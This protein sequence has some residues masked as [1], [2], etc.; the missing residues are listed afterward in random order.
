DREDA[1]VAADLVLEH[2]RLRLVGLHHHL[3]WSAYG[4]PYSP[5]LDL[6]RHER[7]VEQVVEFAGLLASTRGVVVSVINLGGGFRIG[8]PWKFG[9]PGVPGCPPVD[10]YARAVAGRFA[11]LVA[12]YGLGEPVLMLEPGGYLVANA[13]VLLAVVG[14]SKERVTSLGRRRWLF[15]EN[16]S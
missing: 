8:R 16:T 5:E 10:A 2:P 13:G 11:K 6:A 14:L 9:P 15:L 1:L 3:G 7:A 4:L 12:E